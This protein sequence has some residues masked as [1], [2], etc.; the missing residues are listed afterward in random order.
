MALGRRPVRPRLYRGGGTM[1]PFDWAVYTTGA[2]ALFMVCGAAV[3]FVLAWLNDYFEGH[4]RDR[5]DEH[6]VDL[7]PPWVRKKR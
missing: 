7:P 6:V 1:S 2:V 5:E 3:L 4:H